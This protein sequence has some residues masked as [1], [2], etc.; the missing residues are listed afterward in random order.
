[1]SNEKNELRTLTVHP[2]ND[3]NSPVTLVP[4]KITH[5]IT[6]PGKMTVWLDGGAYASFREENY[7]LSG[8]KS[9]IGIARGGHPLGVDYGSVPLEKDIY[10]EFAH[11]E[12]IS[13]A[14]AKQRLF[15]L[16]MFATSTGGYTWEDI[17][18]FVDSLPKE[19]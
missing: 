19:A 13:R 18:S 3:E 9:L 12:G 1:M 10:A 2:T 14:E 5:A 6:S 15:P 4:S 17:R 11:K 7:N 8:L 16:L